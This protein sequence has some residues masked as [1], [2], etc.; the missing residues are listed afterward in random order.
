[1][2]FTTQL[3]Y[4][5]ENIFS[6]RDTADSSRGVCGMYFHNNIIAIEIE[7]LLILVAIWVLQI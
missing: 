5:L 4:V 6:Y 7:K 2:K 1:M 3:E